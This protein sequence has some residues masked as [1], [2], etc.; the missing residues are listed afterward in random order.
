MWMLVEKLGEM[1]VC[2]VLHSDVQ[3]VYKVLAE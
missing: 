3:N 2:F 1:F